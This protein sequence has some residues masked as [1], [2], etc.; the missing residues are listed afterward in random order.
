MC[1]GLMNRIAMTTIHGAQKLE[2]VTE[3]TGIN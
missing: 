2:T 3:M 1:S